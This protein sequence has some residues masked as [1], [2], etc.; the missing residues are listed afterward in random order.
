M[1]SKV[2]L[3][4][5]L[6]DIL[7]GRCWSSFRMVPPGAARGFPQPIRVQGSPGLKKKIPWNISKGDSFEDKHTNYTSTWK[8]GKPPRTFVWQRFST[9]IRLMHHKTNTTPRS[10]VRCLVMVIWL[11]YWRLCLYRKSKY[12][13]TSQDVSQLLKSQTHVQDLLMLRRFPL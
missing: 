6:L 1:F 8:L 4:G 3:Q 5:L 12:W 10:I 7:K 11:K 2:Y 13:L 9:N